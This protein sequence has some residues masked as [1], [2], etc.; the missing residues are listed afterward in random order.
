MSR[1]SLQMPW[2]SVEKFLAVYLPDTQEPLVCAASGGVD[3][4]VMLHLLGEAGYRCIHVVSFDHG[5]RGDTAE[6]RRVV[7]Q[8]ASLYGF[9]VSW[10]S[11]DPALCQS[12]NG[13][14]RERYRH[15]EEVRR[16]VEAGW[17]LTGH[18]GDDLLESQLLHMERG[19]GLWGMVGI[20]P[21]DEERHLLRPLLTVTKTDI[22]TYAHQHAVPWHEDT[23]NEDPRFAR[24][25]LRAQ[26]HEELREH[27]SDVYAW[28]QR[29]SA[30]V[31]EDL[32][33]LHEKTSRHLGPTLEEGYILRSL[34]HTLPT[35][36]QEYI[37]VEFL[38]QA[39]DEYTQDHISS[40]RGRLARMR[41][42]GRV[43]LGED[44]WI[45]RDYDR[46]VLSWVTIPVDALEHV[47][48]PAEEP[49]DLRLVPLQPHMSVRRYRRTQQ[50]WEPWHT[51]LKKWR[52]SVGLAREDAL[53]LS[54]LVSA[55]EE[56]VAIVH[57][58]WQYPRDFP[59]RLHPVP[60]G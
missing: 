15:L 49:A 37:L 24:N 42:G 54:A 56:V 20:R 7:E 29:L 6:D 21:V 5:W 58:K 17:I 45:R 48:V 36:E 30:E 16:R 52:A 14:R 59:T 43:F 40:L 32:S 10:I 38:R 46:F 53:T 31:Q 47:P 34:W 3:S 50:G 60:R 41:T 12:E 19:S 18:H 13:A 28:S 33:V 55:E 35:L 39:G 11:L 2:S 26:G 9:A 57:P 22:L 1:F 27:I 51:P 23:T 4:Q 25:R 8:L 44:R